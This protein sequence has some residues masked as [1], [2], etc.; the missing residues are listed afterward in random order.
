MVIKAIA[1]APG[2]T[3]STAVTASYTIT[4]AP[5]T[6]I[7]TAM[8]DGVK[9]FSDGGGVPA[10]AQ[11]GNL[12]SLAF[13]HSGNLFFVDSTNCVVWQRSAKTGLLSSGATICQTGAGDQLQPPGIAIDSTGNLF[14]ADPNRNVVW[15]V[16]AGTGVTT[17][18]AGEETLYAPP[19][20]EN[21][22]GGPA[23]SAYI[24]EPSGLAVDSAGNLYIADQRGAVRFVSASTGI[25]STV[26]GL[27]NEMVGLREDNIPATTANLQNP[28]ALALDSSGNLYIAQPNVGRVRKVT[29]S[30][31]IITTVAGTGD[32][33]SS[34]DGGPATQAEVNPM[35][36]AFDSAGNLYI[37]DPTEIRKVAQA[38]GII[39][40]FA[41]NRY[42]GYSGDGGSATVAEIANP[43]GIAFDASGNLYFADGGNYRIREVSVSP[44]VAVAPGISVTPS[45]SSIT[46]AQPLTVTVIVTGSAAGSTPTGSITLASG[47]Y[48]A[49]QNLAAGSTSFSLAANSLP[50]GSDTL[51]ATYAPD[52]ASAGSYLAAK[53]NATVTV[54]NPIG[55]AIATITLTP[56]VSTV[57]DQQSVTVVATIAGSGG[58]GMPT[59]SVTLSGGASYSSQQAVANGQASFSIPAGSLTAG[60]NAL[61][62]SY[63]GDPNYATA[64]GTITVAVVPLVITV[65]NPPAT[66]PGTAATATVT[67]S[68]GST[69]SGTLNLTCTATASPANAQSVPTCALSPASVTVAAQGKASALVTVSTVAGSSNSALNQRGEEGILA[70]G[71]LVG[72]FGRRRR[73]AALLLVV[74]GLVIVGCGGGGS[75]S[76]KSIPP[77]T[78]AATS[79][80]SYTF[81]VTANDASNP[82][83]TASANLTVVVQ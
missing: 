74:C 72:A 28:G 76:T 53:Q 47:S 61:T 18:Y 13:D 82:K 4:A 19:L 63:S 75:G 68:A 49:Q 30:T 2:Y 80:G 40:S 67:L 20:T 69:Y 32:A 26:A 60:S 46:T 62:A 66:A 56:S 55:T 41:G 1:A 16:A 54:T 43:Q 6:V 81:A 37:S 39:S 27:G 12:S 50:A 9:G 83:L 3:P 14:V 78:T 64:T 36:L 70:L 42:Y 31:G 35:G 21:G 17:I 73:K 52:D 5:P 48:S 79:P 23:T 51:T 25:I 77:P 58:L 33:G 11:L 29:L 38:T 15:K 8:G 7:E 24:L 22:N 45:A 34:G 44:H 59:G 10:D 71:L 65:P 57:T